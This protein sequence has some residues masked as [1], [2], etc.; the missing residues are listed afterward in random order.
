MYLHVDE[1]AQNVTLYII[2]PDP[3]QLDCNNLSD[4]PS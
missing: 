1:K 4:A 2:C 3:N